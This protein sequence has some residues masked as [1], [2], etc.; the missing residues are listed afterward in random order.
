MNGYM[1]AILT[2][3]NGYIKLGFLKLFHWKSISFGSLPRISINTEVSVESGGALHVGDRFN[4][5]GTSRIRSNRGAN[6]VI[7]DNVLL[8]NGCMIVCHSSIVLGNDI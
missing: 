5:R 8:S 6:L 3:P 4:M 1:R 7:G 2:I